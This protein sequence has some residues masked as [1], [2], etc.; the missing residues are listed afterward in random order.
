MRRQK[1]QVGCGFF[2]SLSADAM[3]GKKKKKKNPKDKGEFSIKK[4]KDC[5]RLL[6]PT[7][8]FFFL[9]KKSRL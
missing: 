6:R 4:F 2:H 5:V 9:K 8:M 1:C 7:I 3:L